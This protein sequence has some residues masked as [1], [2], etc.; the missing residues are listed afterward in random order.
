M[1]AAVP[2]VAAFHRAELDDRV[3]TDPVFQFC[4]F[5]F[6]NC[7]GE[8]VRARRIMPRQMGVV[9][10]LG[11]VAATSFDLLEGGIIAVMILPCASV[12]RQSNIRSAR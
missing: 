10:R 3:G 4:I 1:G 12:A 7:S 8:A 5:T 6:R 2:A 11:W 9:G